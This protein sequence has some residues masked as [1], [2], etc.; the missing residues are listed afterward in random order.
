MVGN[1]GSQP[2]RRTNPKES[3]HPVNSKTRLAHGLRFHEEERSRVSPGFFS[4]LP[5]VA[6]QYP[7]IEIGTI[8]ALGLELSFDLR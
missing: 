1:A 6:L 7:T 3:S 8:Q 2:A 4:G 5:G